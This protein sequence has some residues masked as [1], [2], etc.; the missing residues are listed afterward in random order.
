M[1]LAFLL[2]TS[3][4]GMQKLK[5]IK[6]RETQVKRKDKLLALGFVL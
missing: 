6:N 3:K 1:D 4:K 5:L 2:D